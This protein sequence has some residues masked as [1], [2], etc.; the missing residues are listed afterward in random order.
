MLGNQPERPCSRV[1][2]HPHQIWHYLGHL[3]WQQQLIQ[4][5]IWQR[6]VWGSSRMEGRSGGQAAHTS[7]SSTREGDEAA[8]YPLWG[9]G[10]CSDAASAWQQPRAGP[11]WTCVGI[12]VCVSVSLGPWLEEGICTGWHL[13]AG[14]TTSLLICPFLFFLSSLLLFS[15]CVKSD[16]QT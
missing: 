9:R 10:R 13:W 5:G 7:K 2:S 16:S 8:L 4:K 11:R 14:P 6:S 15:Y 1:Q 3:W 12:E